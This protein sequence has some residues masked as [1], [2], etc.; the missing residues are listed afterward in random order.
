[1]HPLEVHGA[2][3]ASRLG[4]HLE[5]VLHQQRKPTALYGDAR[6]YVLV[7]DRIGEHAYKMAV[8]AVVVVV[9]GEVYV[10]DRRGVRD[11]IC[12]VS[13]ASGVLH[14][15]IAQI[16]GQFSNQGGDVAFSLDRF[17]EIQPNVLYFFVSGEAL[18]ARYDELSRSRPICS[19]VVHKRHEPEIVRGVNGRSRQVP[20]RNCVIEL[21]D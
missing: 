4:H 18:V 2:K 16:I 5:I 19:N 12:D 3:V 11:G 14:L 13:G 15:Q 1:M 21:I 17:P 9:D 20:R 6:E 7:E 10:P 8:R